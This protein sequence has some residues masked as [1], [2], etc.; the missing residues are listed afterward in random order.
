MNERPSQYFVIATTVIFAAILLFGLFGG[1]GGF[2]TPKP[3]P[4]PTP[5]ES[6]HLARLSALRAAVPDVR[7]GWMDHADGDSD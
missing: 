4:E 1:R 6:N 3:T 7:I 5:I 2:L